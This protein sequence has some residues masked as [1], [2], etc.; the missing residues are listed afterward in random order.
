MYLFKYLHKLIP[1]FL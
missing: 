1:Y